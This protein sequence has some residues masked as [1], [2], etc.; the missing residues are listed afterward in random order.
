VL[1]ESTADGLVRVTAAIG[2]TGNGR[3]KSVRSIATARATT[4]RSPFHQARQQ[5]VVHPEDD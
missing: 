5:P 4:R 3:K 1:L 2:S